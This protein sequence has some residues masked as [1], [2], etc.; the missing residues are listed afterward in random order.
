MKITKKKPLIIVEEEDPQPPSE[1]NIY[2]A[3]TVE[4]DME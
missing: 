4:V 2:Y 1:K 3:Q